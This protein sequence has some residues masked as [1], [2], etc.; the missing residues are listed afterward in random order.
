MPTPY[1]W[2]DGSATSAGIITNWTGAWTSSKSYTLQDGASDNGSSYVC[3]LAHT[4]ASINEPGV[5]AN[6]TTYWNLVSQKGNTGSAG[7]E[8]LIQVSGGY[9]QWKYTADV[10]WT[11]LIAVSTLV[12]ATGATGE[13]GTAGKQ[14]EL[15]KTSTHIQW[16]YVGESWTDL[17]LL[18]DLKGSKGDTGDTGTNG[19]NGLDITWCGEYADEISYVIN[20]AVSY[21]GS[22]Y[23]CKLAST[24][25]IP[26][27]TT[28]WDLMAQKGDTGTGDFMADGS[29]PMTGAI[30]LGNDME[31]TST[32]G[33]TFQIKQ[34][35][36]VLTAQIDLQNLS[37]SRRYTLPDRADTIATLSDITSPLW[38]LDTVESGT[39]IY[40]TNAGAVSINGADIGALEDNLGVFGVKS[41]DG[42]T[43]PFIIFKSGV[44][45]VPIFTFLEDSDGNGGSLWRDNSGNLKAVISSNGLSYFNGGNVG[46]GVSIPTAYLHLKA[47]TT[48]AGT[49]PI[50]LNSGS[51]MTVPE[52]GAIEFLNDNFYATITTGAVRKTIA[53]TD[54]IPVKATSSEVTTGT[55]DTKF[56]T[57]K[58]IKDAGI[59]AVTFPVKASGSEINTGTDDAKFATAKAISDST[60]TTTTKT[61]TLTNKRLT[62]RVASTTDNATAAIDSDS[63]DEYYLTAIANNTTISVTGTPTAGQT[64]FI[65]LKD[66]G[67]SKT[68]TWSSITALGCTLPT[69]TTA[70]KQHIIGLKYIASAWRAIAVAVE[71]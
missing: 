12:G 41:K 23:I 11:N 13:Q 48:A 19:T 7:Q 26:T 46:I 27:D 45:T 69:A 68:L 14:I 22:S 57:P 15:Q 33:N 17:V 36:S 40:N 24:G 5:G 20:D 6:W 61:Q 70:S 28:H 64:I 44:S 50:K 32:D 55:D 29:V 39:S 59:V 51:L 53:F 21:L 16:R 63:Y 42:D 4:S 58:A 71:A 9:I 66:A 52:V 3:I 65:G 18:S 54:A 62:K 25:N 35:S 8:V 43:S 56:A 60:I 47:G 38:A 49:A 30:K 37:S 67:V 10:S 1:K 34:G 31:I 2:E